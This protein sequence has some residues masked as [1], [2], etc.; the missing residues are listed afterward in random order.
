MGVQTRSRV[1]KGALNQRPPHRPSRAARRR[2]RG[3]VGLHFLVCPLDWLCRAVLVAHFKPQRAVV[4][5]S[6]DEGPKWF[7]HASN[8]GASTSRP[9]A[10]HCEQSD[11]D[12]DSDRDDDAVLRAGDAPPATAATAP[13]LLAP[14][15]TS[16]MAR[17]P[18]YMPLLGFIGGFVV[19]KTA[20]RLPEDCWHVRVPQSVTQRELWPE[21]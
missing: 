18:S 9:S 7:Q 17:G 2:P 11:G 14:H 8:F 1:L 6:C 16:A 19:A 20:L 13:T 15:P 4:Y 3:L 10:L 12:D 5:A 21:E